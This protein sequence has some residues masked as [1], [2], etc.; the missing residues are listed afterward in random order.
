MKGTLVNI[1]L[2]G[3][4]VLI[5]SGV[6]WVASY[7]PLLEKPQDKI[8]L[9]EVLKYSNTI[10]TKDNYSCEGEIQE[11]VGDVVA[12]II[13]L[14]SQHKRNNLS[15]GCYG[16]TCALAVSNCMPWQNQECGNRI[17]RFNID[18]NDEIL[19]STFTCID[20]P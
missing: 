13:D 6:T 11:T 15:F 14:N 2:L 1:L 20:M 9:G 18:S 4:G 12:S 16:D 19:E 17:L 10:I 8:E 5:G 3:F 7:Y